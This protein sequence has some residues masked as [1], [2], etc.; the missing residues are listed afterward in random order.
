MFL[1]RCSS[2]EFKC[3]N[4]E[5]CIRTRFKCDGDNDCSDNSDERNCPGKI[6]V[7]TM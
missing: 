4:G 6:C 7:I 3:D 5:K 2:G 1:V